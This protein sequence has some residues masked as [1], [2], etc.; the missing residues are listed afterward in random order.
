MKFVKKSLTTFILSAGARF[1]SVSA[2]SPIPDPATLLYFYT[3]DYDTACSTLG[4]GYTDIINPQECEAARDYYNDGDFQPFGPAGPFRT[5][6]STDYG[7]GCV[8]L[9]PIITGAFP[10]PLEIVYNTDSTG[11]T[12][13]RDFFKVCKN[14]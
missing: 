1:L 3:S 11:G 12:G 2:F 7:R 8:G 13:T 10:M 4:Q 9:A 6:F 14:G 5:E